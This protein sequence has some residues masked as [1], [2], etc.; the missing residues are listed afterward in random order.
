MQAQNQSR[1]RA[2][3]YLGAILLLAM[4]DLGAHPSLL[5]TELSPTLAGLLGTQR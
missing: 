1:D 2:D 5:A 3:V 4:A